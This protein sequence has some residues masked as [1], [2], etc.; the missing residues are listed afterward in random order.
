MHNTTQNRRLSGFTLVEVMIAAFI[1]FLVLA[2]VITVLVASQRIYRDTIADCELTFKSCALR[3]KLLYDLGDEDAGGLS[4]ALRNGTSSP[5]QS[6]DKKRLDYL[7]ANGTSGYFSIS[8]T[9]LSTDDEDITSWVSPT[10]VYFPENVELFSVIS[11]N[12]SGSNNFVTVDID[13]RMLNGIRKYGH[14]LRV[15]SQL[16]NPKN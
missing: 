12:S 8:D 14:K 15:V 2:Q 5:K 7:K 16:V 3:E 10:G 6:A 9:A 1:G 4:M 13:L 11:S